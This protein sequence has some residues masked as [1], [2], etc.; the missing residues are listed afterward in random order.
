MH[1]GFA[2]FKFIL[3]MMFLGAAIV[4]GLAFVQG[5]SCLILGLS[6]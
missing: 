5:L 4:F 3:Q 2:T 6:H 1:E